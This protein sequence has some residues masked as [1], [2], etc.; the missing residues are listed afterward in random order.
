MIEINIDPTMFTLGPLVITWHGFFSA[1]GLAVALWIVARLVE[2]SS[3][4]PD[5]VYTVALAAVPGGIVGARLLFVAENWRLFSNNPLGVLAINEGGISVYGAVI[6]GSIAGAVF[7]RYSRR[8]VAFL[9]DRAAMGL[10]MGQAIGRIGDVINGEHLG[11][12]ADLPWSVTYTH[13]LT[14]GEQGLA[15][16]PAVAYELAYDLLVALALY[17]FLP[18]QSREGLT[19]VAYLFLYAVGRLWVGFYRKDMLV[20]AGLGMAQLIAVVFL[21]AS[22]VW[23]LWLL[24]KAQGPTRAARRRA[25]SR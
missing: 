12:E 10:I 13:P 25:A 21:I 9:A 22:A 2:G 15:V 16:H 4:T 20:A 24:R 6:G 5:D 1:V 17:W 8:P 14:L 7:A 23:F 19:Y 11:K 3:V 18:R